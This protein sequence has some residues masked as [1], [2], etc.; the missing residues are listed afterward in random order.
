MPKFLSKS[1]EITFASDDTSYEDELISI[2]D[3][4][5]SDYI[6]DLFLELS[7]AS[8][9]H[10]VTAKLQFYLGEDLDQ[11][12]G[13]LNVDDASGIKFT[14]EDNANSNP[15]TS[16]LTATVAGAK[17]ETRLSFKD[18]WKICKGFRLIYYKSAGKAVTIKRKVFGK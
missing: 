7:V 18:W 12:Y 11:K 13:L 9:T 8:G 14:K 15:E 4:E 2:P 10:D 6:V 3:Y 1:R 16:T 5:D 17:F